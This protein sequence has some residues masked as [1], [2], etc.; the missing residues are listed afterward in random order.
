MADP[1]GPAA[2]GQRLPG[3]AAGRALG[4]EYSGQW[5]RTDIIYWFSGDLVSPQR[6]RRIF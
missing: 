1:G 6:G 5:K 3:V 2:A 4:S